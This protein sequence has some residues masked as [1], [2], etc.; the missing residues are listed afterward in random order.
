WDWR[1]SVGARC[2]AVDGRATRSGPAWGAAES[3]AAMPVETAALPR[4]SASLGK[5]LAEEAGIGDAQLAHAVRQYHSPDHAAVPRRRGPASPRRQDSRGGAP[6]DEPR[7]GRG[8]GTGRPATVHRERRRPV[9]RAGQPRLRA[10]HGRRAQD[11]R[12]EARRRHPNGAVRRPYGQLSPAGDGTEG[13]THTT[14]NFISRDYSMFSLQLYSICPRSDFVISR[15]DLETASSGPIHPCLPFP[16]RR[17]PSPGEIIVE[18][19]PGCSSR[20][21]PPKIQVRFRVVFWDRLVELYRS[22]ASDALRGQLLGELRSKIR[23]DA[24][25][26]RSSHP[27]RETPGTGLVCRTRTFGIGRKVASR[28]RLVEHKRLSVDGF[29]DVQVGSANGELEL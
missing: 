12:G 15:D 4:S 27:P 3:A 19:L 10:V 8:G 25:L 14:I 2:P 1:R 20:D 6:E 13:R 21:I 28:D 24:R 7:P 26:E 16:R 17:E 5:A 9:H 22:A 29:R 11:Q 18:N 23:H